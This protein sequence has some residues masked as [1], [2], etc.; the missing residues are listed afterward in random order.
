MALA[1][2][3][4]RGQSFA[5]SATTAASGD[6]VI[7]EGDEQPPLLEEVSQN[8]SPSPAASAPVYNMDGRAVGTP[9]NSRAD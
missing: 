6:E 9:Y 5:V 7:D 8:A 3:M 1:C 4:P 2:Q